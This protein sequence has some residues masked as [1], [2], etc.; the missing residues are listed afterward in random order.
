M[1][2]YY[3]IEESKWVKNEGYEYQTVFDAG[4]I[5]GDDYKECLFDAFAGYDDL[6]ENEDIVWTYR[7]WNSIESYRD[8]DKPIYE[9]SVLDSSYR[10]R[11]EK[12]M[13]K[14]MYKEMADDILDDVIRVTYEDESKDNESYLSLYAWDVCRSRYDQLEDEEVDI[15]CNIV[16]M[17]YEDL[18]NEKI[19]R[20]IE[21][22]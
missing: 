19:L 3:E 21:I 14:E 8:G 16:S 18:K 1:Q 9:K 5:D 13:K 4:Y 22:C 17:W 7:V 15:V 12:E 2:K 10:E 20:E 6:N 11:E